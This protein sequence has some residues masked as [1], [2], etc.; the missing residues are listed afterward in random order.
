MFGIDEDISAEVQNLSD[1]L[2]GRPRETRGDL[3]RG[4]SAEPFSANVYWNQMGR[5]GRLYGTV[6][7]PF[8]MHVGD[9]GGRDE[10][11]ARLKIMGPGS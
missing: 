9:P 4:Y 6:M 10:A 8:W 5:A 11:E 1:V 7:A 3:L 2:A